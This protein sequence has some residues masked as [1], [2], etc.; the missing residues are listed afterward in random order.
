MLAYAHT[1]DINSVCACVYVCTFKQ[2]IEECTRTTASR[3]KTKRQ[4][5]E[6][7]IWTFPL[8]FLLLNC[9]VNSSVY[10]YTFKTAEKATQ[11]PPAGH[12][13]NKHDRKR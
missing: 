3:T 10:I 9:C 6:T 12:L 5:D 4:Q 8:I 1:Y 7:Y 2:I 11:K 13:P